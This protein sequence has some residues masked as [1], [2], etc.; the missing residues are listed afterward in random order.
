M[1]EKQFMTASEVAEEHSA[2]SHVPYLAVWAWLAVLTAVE[3]VYAYACQE[4]LLTPFLVTLGGLLIWAVIKAGLVGWFFMHLKFEGPWVYGLI[5]PAC[6]LAA[7][8]VLALA[9]DIAFRPVTEEQE[10]E[11]VLRMAPPAIFRAAASA[12]A[13]TLARRAG[14]GY[15]ER[16]GGI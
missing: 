4:I 13:V 9:P 8:L 2:E 7:I 1:A 6:V 3:Y 11:E 16:I 12:E 10:E 15:G 5:I 14:E